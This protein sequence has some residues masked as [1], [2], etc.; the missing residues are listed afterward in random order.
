MIDLGRERLGRER[1]G[2]DEACG[3]PTAILK[4]TYIVLYLWLPSLLSSLRLWA[5]GLLNSAHSTLL[6]L[7]LSSLNN[8]VAREHVAAS[9]DSYT[10]VE[11]L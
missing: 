2:R 10:I 5:I 8:D 9:N 4:S 6:M 3:F 7:L 11:F 1:L